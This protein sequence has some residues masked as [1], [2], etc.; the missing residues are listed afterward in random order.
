MVELMKLGI[1]RRKARCISIVSMVYFF[2]VVARAR[3]FE[4]FFCIFLFNSNIYFRRKREFF[5]GGRLVCE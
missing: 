2:G 3:C 1:V 4:R 5:G